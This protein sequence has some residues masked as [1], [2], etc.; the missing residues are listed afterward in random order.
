MN[1]SKGA[2]KESLANLRNVFVKF[3]M[4]I[5]LLYITTPQKVNFTQMRHYNFHCELIYITQIAEI[6]GGE[7]VRKL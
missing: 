6:R 2:I 5:L 1:I 4:G 7:T 3:L